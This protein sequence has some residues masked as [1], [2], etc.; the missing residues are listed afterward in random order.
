MEMLPDIWINQSGLQLHSL[1][2]F[3]SQHSEFVDWKRFL[4]LASS[5]LTIPT[6]QELFDTL[7]RFMAIDLEETGCVSEKQFLEVN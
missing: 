5:P 2:T 4:V 6:R 3:I 1:T 7:S